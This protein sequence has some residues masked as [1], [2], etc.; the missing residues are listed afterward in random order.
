MR[1][2]FINVPTHVSKMTPEQ[3]AAQMNDLVKKVLDDNAATRAH[4]SELHR[5]TQG[6]VDNLADTLRTGLREDV[7]LMLQPVTAK[8]D[9]HSKKL[10]DHET[11]IRGLETA[12]TKRDV[13]IAG[14]ASLA[15]VAIAE[16]VRAVYR[17]KTGGS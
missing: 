1:A 7:E 3:F 4:S 2:S 6:R 16:G 11:R 8:V 15:M 5:A 9:S 14:G 17:W 10:D 13:V 12:S